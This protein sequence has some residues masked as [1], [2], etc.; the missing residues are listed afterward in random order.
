MIALFNQYRIWI[1]SALALIVLVF[2]FRKK[3]R[4]TYVRRRTYGA[5]RRVYSR[6]RRMTRRK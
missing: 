1:L 6:A 2:V 4:R 5:A 3:S